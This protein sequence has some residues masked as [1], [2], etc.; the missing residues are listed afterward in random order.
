MTTKR[1]TGG[2]RGFSTAKESAYGAAATVDTAFNFEGDPVDIEINNDQDNGEEITGLNEPDAHEILNYKLDGTHQQRV[3]PHNIAQFLGM[4][5]GKVTDDQ[6]DAG[7]NSSVYRH[8]FER[9]L[10]RFTIT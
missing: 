2:F 10:V 8:W 4:V 1:I 6:P 9:E 7:G 3:T 5:L